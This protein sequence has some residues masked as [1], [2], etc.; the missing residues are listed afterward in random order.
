MISKVLCV[1]TIAMALSMTSA[2]ANDYG[3]SEEHHRDNGSYG[4]PTRV[5]IPAVPQAI[6]NPNGITQIAIHPHTVAEV[7][8]HAPVV[9]DVTNVG[10]ANFVGIDSDCGCGIVGILQHAD[11]P[12]TTAVANVGAQIGG[13]LTNFAAAN[14]TIVKM[15][16][17]KK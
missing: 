11:H 2:I 7:N 16:G 9:G 5:P 1:L 10:A 17:S 4:V 13:N 8:I 3:Y 12:Q 15:G 6:V 14:A